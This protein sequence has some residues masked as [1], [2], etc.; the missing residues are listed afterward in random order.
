MRA[1]YGVKTTRIVKDRQGPN[2][3][4]WNLRTLPCQCMSPWQSTKYIPSN[5]SRPFPGINVDQGC[6]T[7]LTHH[8][9]HI[10]P[11]FYLI[12]RIPASATCRWNRRRVCNE[13]AL[14]AN[15]RNAR[16]LCTYIPNPAL[17]LVRYKS[18]LVNLIV[19]AAHGDY[20]S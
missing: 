13:A 16:R 18:E 14:T 3:P 20:L 2:I 6:I 10:H 11:L 1:S 19:S 7:P 17:S 9:P 4:I 15:P 5:A 8:S 12:H